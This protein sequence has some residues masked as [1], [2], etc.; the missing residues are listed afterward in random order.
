[1]EKMHCHLFIHSKPY[2]INLFRIYSQPLFKKLDRFIKDQGVVTLSKTTLSI[3]TFS[4]TT[5][6]IVTQ[7]ITTLM[8]SFIMLSVPYTQCP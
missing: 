6:S 4:K 1:M 8:Q 2:S 5:L 7:R 3:V